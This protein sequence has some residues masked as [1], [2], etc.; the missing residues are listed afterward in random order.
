MHTDLAR[1][2]ALLALGTIATGATRGAAAETPAVNTQPLR[3]AYYGDLH[4][5]TSYS[6]DAYLGGA[7]R[8]DAASHWIFSPSRITSK[9]SASSMGWTIHRAHSRVAPS[10]RL[11]KLSST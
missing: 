9:A 5:H 6:L 10:A 1:T 2:A 3:Q 4:L 11:C 8:C 7:M